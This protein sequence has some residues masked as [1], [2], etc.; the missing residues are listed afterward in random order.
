MGF[1]IRYATNV[2]ERNIRGYI[3]TEKLLEEYLLEVQII[4]NVK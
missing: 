4:V 3:E 1:V 2:E